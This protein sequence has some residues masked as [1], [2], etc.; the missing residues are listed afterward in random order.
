MPDIPIMADSDTTDGGTNSSRSDYVVIARRY[1][2]Q[3]FAELIGQEHVAK[4][5][6]AAIAASRVGHA[7]LFTGARGTGKTSSA[8][9]LAKCL[10][11]EQG[12]TPSPC[13]ECDICISITAGNDMDVLEIDGAS[14][15]G[16]D[17]IRQLRQNVNVRPSRSRFKIYIIDEVHM[18]T[19]EAFNALLKTLEEPPEHVKFIFCTTEPEK[20]PITILSRC[21]RFDFAGIQTPQ[22]IERL[23]F[24]AE[25]E[26]VKTEP[27]ALEI[28]ARRAA[29]SMRDSQS[30]L[31]QLLAF[32]GKKITV[33]DV[34]NLLGTAG[35][36]RIR[37]L[38]T[39]LIERNAAAA[40]ADLDAA[41]TQGVDIG[42]L[43]DQLLGYF[44][45]LMAV[46]V[47]CPADALLHVSASERASAQEAATRIGLQT[48]MA[49]M[50]IIDQ[51]LSRLKYLSYPRIVAELAL[52]RLCC[53][54]DLDSLPELIS[55]LQTGGP[56]SP[57]AQSQPAIAP[58]KK[59]FAVSEDVGGVLNGAPP[60]S[61]AGYSN[62][63]APNGLGTNGAAAHS[64]GANANGASSNDIADDE[65]QPTPRAERPETEAQIGHYS[66]EAALALW[67]QAA[68]ELGG[69]AGD[70]AKQAANA[71]IH[72]PNSLVVFFPAKYNFG[73]ERCESPENAKRLVEILSQLAGGFVRLS[74]QTVENE[75]ETAAARPVSHRQYAQT[76]CERP[77]VKNILDKFDARDVRVDAPR[78]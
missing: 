8:R 39:S 20:I 5:L 77:Y 7:Y 31:E 2:P 43:M 56:I 12:P 14:N 73:R 55:Q 33:A 26:G 47:G 22:I 36:E 58:A 52:V 62:G 32:G 57:I 23:K 44:R 10:N 42:Q 15:R 9:I 54:E 50:Q 63:A 70:T 72:A 48:I 27:E 49:A 61:N 3:S 6:A 25:S 19:K 30:L 71:A 68:E 59:K 45:D 60:T 65:P 28:L 76:V 21:Q 75:P 66:D 13:N 11:C 53:L 67:H 17:E 40:L 38:V 29:G 18:L 78:K 1:R 24:I 51:T 64:N 37:H 46:A 4:G 35:A 34:H 16:I 69:L 41:L 74:F